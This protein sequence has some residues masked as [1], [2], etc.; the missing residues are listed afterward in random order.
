MSLL[1]VNDFSIQYQSNGRWATA[2]DHVSFTLDAT[3]FIGI[4]GESGCGKSSLAHGLL[5]LLPR[6]ARVTHGSVKLND[7]ELLHLT[8][9]TWQPVRWRQMAVVLQS[10]M[11]ALNP[12]LRIH[13][14]FDDVYHAH[15]VKIGQDILS[16]QALLELVGVPASRLHAYP[17]QLSGGQR[18]RVAIALALTLNPQLIVMDEPTTALDVVVQREIFDMLQKI[19]QE[20]AFAVILVTHDLSLLLERASK[21]LVMYAGRVVEECDSKVIARQPRHPYTMGLL[22]AFPRIGGQRGII[23]SIEGNPPAIDHLPSGCAFHPRCARRSDTCLASS[24][25]LITLGRGRVACHHPLGD[26]EV[27]P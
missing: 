6:A 13:Q 15:G 4:A 12:V 3:D 2:V 27:L 1:E 23:A 24:P 26:A 19:R 21:I 17:H 16:P 14:Q 18:Q 25:G 8:E 5:G 7:Q 20:R 22:Q 10:G 9:E 11:N